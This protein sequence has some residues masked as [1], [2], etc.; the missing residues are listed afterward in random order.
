MFEGVL[1]SPI[2]LSLFRRFWR[3]FSY[4]EGVLISHICH[5]V[6]EF[7]KYWSSLSAYPSHYVQEAKEPA[8]EEAEA[9]AAPWEKSYP[10]HDLCQHLDL[11]AEPFSEAPVLPKIFCFN[12]LLICA[13]YC[14]QP[15]SLLSIIMNKSASCIILNGALEIHSW[16]GHTKSKK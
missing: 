12:K 10:A 7:L 16:A 6:Q 3:M 9:A 2:R 11:K 8:V 1:M 14:H 4:F 15:I 5:S 13:I